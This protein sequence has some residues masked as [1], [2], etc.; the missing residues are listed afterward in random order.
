[1][2]R[3]AVHRAP[4]PEASESAILGGCLAACQGFGVLAWRQQ[5]GAATIGGRHVRFGVRGQ[6]DILGVVRRGPHR[7]RLLA[8][9]VKRPGQRPRPRQ[10]LW[11]RDVIE[12]GG[13]AW[14]TDGVADCVDVLGRVLIGGA[15]V[16][17][18]KD[19]ERRVVEG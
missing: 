14:W 6:S 7:G 1:M 9:E 15:T 4:G 13:I 17:I 2:T 5:V 3:R 12:A 11:L 10:V 8:I 16:Q 18:D 19:G